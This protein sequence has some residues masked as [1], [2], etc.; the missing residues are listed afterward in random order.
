MADEADLAEERLE[1]YIEEGRVQNAQRLKPERH[2]DF[3][4]VNCVECGTELPTLRLEMGRIRCTPCQSA[5]EYR[6]RVAA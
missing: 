3:D 5:L 1:S 4:G 2:P 6:Q